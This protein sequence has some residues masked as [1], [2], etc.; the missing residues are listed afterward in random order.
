MKTLTDAMKDMLAKQTPIRATVTKTG[1]PTI[2]PSA[3]CGSMT[4]G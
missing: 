2:D 3:A 4:T 1:I